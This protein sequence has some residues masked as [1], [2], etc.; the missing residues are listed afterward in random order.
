MT[1]IT[2]LALICPINVTDITHCIQEKVVDQ[3]TADLTM[4][5]CMGYEGQLSAQRFVSEHP[6][7]GNKEEWYFQGW[8]CIVGNKP[9]PDGRNI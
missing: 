9:A 4:T 2:L 6:L 5:T 7:Y 1:F 3:Y 8:K